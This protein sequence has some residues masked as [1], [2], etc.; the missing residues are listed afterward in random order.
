MI[1]RRSLLAGAVALPLVG[2]GRGGGSSNGTGA[3]APTCRTPEELKTFGTIND[4]PLRYEITD[5]KHKFQA[6]PRFIKQLGA[7]AKDWEKW[8]GLGAITGI[9]T[10]GAFVDKCGSWH[11]AGRAFDFAVV[12]HENGSVS[13]RHDLWGDDAKRLR[14]YWRLAASLT[15]HF[16]YTLTLSYNDQ[17]DNHIH[18][19][20]GV[21]G[22]DATRFD[23]TSHTQVQVIQGVVRH[24][25]G[26][27]APSSGVYDEATKDAVRQTQAKLGISEPLASAGGW[28]SWLK[29][30]A[31]AD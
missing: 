14:R 18:V 31:L 12:D 17:H 13:C 5:E 15:L 19:D 11:S 22:Y 9:S 3:V 26:I 8:S 29:A 28:E 16:T 23:S 7:W 24:V 25:Y 20:N 6:D 30:A 4:A 10:Y 27:D 1:S 2:C 21:N